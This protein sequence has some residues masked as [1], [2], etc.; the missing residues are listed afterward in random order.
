MNDNYI[1]NR[2]DSKAGLRSI[3]VATIPIITSYFFT[4]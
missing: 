1:R 4:G 2:V 3:A